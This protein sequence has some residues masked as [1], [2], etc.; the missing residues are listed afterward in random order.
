MKVA[1][2]TSLTYSLGQITLGLLLHPYQTMQ[3]LVED[4]VFVWMSLLPVSA[5]TAIIVAWRFLVV[6]TVRIFFSCQSNHFWACDYLTFLANWVTLF[7]IYWQVLLIYLLLR[8][9]AAWRE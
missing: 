9:Y 4:K 1:H 7:A 6:P 8:F 2:L 3:Q 5:L